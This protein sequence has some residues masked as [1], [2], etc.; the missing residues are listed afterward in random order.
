MKNPFTEI[1][2]ETISNSL[3]DYINY[4][5]ENLSEDELIGGIS[6]LDR[7]NS[8]QNKIDDLLKLMEIN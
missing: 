6:I 8:I 2:L 1:E 5:D 3:D 7:V 4:H